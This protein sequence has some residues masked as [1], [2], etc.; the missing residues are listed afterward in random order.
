M[1][2]VRSFNNRWYIQCTIKSFKF[3]QAQYIDSPSE[4]QNETK[5]LVIFSSLKLDS[6]K[7]DVALFF[8]VAIKSIAMRRYPY[9]L[10]RGFGLKNA[11]YPEVYPTKKLLTDYSP[12][13]C[14]HWVTIAEWMNYASFSSYCVHAFHKLTFNKE[15]VKNYMTKVMISQT[16]QRTHLVKIV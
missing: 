4:L 5:A 16:I 10:T 6:H 14:I 3:S 13:H 12:H 15:N 11:Q 1:L 9:H 2:I 8:L 7:R